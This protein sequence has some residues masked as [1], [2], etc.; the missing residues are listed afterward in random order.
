[1]F[2]RSRINKNGAVWSTYLSIPTRF[3]IGRNLG[4]KWDGKGFSMHIFRFI[5]RGCSPAWVA[6]LCQVLLL[7]L[8][9]G[10]SW[11]NA[12]ECREYQGY[13]VGEQVNDVQNYHIELS[14]PDASRLEM[15]A[16]I[17]DVDFPSALAHGLG[18]LKDSAGQCFT[19]M[20][21]LRIREGSIGDVT[22]ASSDTWEPFDP[23]TRQSDGSLVMLSLD[24]LDGVVDT[25]IFRYVSASPQFTLQPLFS[26][27]AIA[28]GRSSQRL[29][30]RRNEG[31][32]SA[33][34]LFKGK[35][36][37]LL[38]RVRGAR[39]DLPQKAPSGRRLGLRP[40]RLR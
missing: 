30:Q 12:S 14:V 25:L 10:L 15:R 6:T 40:T 38:G 35:Q 33:L 13:W 18:S 24:T 1:M 36:H 17:S 5:K 3:K 4:E 39:S 19:F 34:I 7:P 37:D 11:V 31:H 16:Q 26:I 23:I 8:T 21:T 22:G 27:S 20:D 9:L 29:W 28:F 32:G 2:V